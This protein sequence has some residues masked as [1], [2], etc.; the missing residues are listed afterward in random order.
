MCKGLLG[1]GSQSGSLLCS[2]ATHRARLYFL[3]WKSI[4]ALLPKILSRL[5][6]AFEVKC[7]HFVMVAQWSPDLNLKVSLLGSR[8]LVKMGIPGFSYQ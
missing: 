5:L 1:T 3:K 4:L 6:V 7:G 8:W 2:K